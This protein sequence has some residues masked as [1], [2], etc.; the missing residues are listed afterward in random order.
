LADPHLENLSPYEKA[1]GMTPDI[2]AYMHFTFYDPV[3]YYDEHEKFPS[4]KEQLGYWLGP[5]SN[6]GDAL[7]YWI[8]TEDNT[9]VARSTVRP[10]SDSSTL[11]HRRSPPFWCE[12]G[13]APPT[14]LSPDEHP[15]FPVKNEDCKLVTGKELLEDTPQSASCTLPSIDIDKF[16]GY[17]FVKEHKGTKQRA[18]VKRYMEEAGKFLVELVNGGEVLMNYNDLINITNACEDDDEKLWTYEKITGHRQIKGVKWEVK[19]LWDT[20]ESTWEPMEVIKADD[21][22]SLA[23]YARDNKLLDIPRWK[24]A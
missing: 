11:N 6:C 14:I 12:G 19:V 1:T 10:A 16:V 24:W 13:S 15:P 8:L 17:H 21:K 7:T 18:F 9:I 22:F 5:T 20:G 23:A 3:Y 2:S 4:S